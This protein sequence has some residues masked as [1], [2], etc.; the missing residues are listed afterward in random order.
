MARYNQKMR[1]QMELKLDY[2]NMMADF[3]GEEQGF[4]NLDIKI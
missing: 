2:N 3:I 1:K 4:T